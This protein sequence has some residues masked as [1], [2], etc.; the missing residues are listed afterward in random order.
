MLDPTYDPPC[1]PDCARIAAQN[2]YDVP[3]RGQHSLW[4]SP[5][6]GRTWCGADCTCTLTHEL[7]SKAEQR[8][9]HR[10]ALAKLTAQ[11]RIY[12]HLAPKQRRFV[13]RYG[14]KAGRISSG[15][16]VAAIVLLDGALIKADSDQG[17][18]T[19]VTPDHGEM[20]SL[21]HTH[22]EEVPPVPPKRKPRLQEVRYRLSHWP[23]R[24]LLW[25]LSTEALE[26][27]EKVAPQFPECEEYPWWF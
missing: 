20:I 6:D 10:E 21:W 15:A 16:D 1:C 18:V 26:E 19:E 8:R 7:P 23:Y 9:R 2:P 25:V 12:R 5:G 17:F 27:W 11:E 24:N 3:G 13:L 4:Q 14:L 22:E